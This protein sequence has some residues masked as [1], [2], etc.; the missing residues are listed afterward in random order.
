M[1]GRFE[2]FGSAGPPSGWRPAQPQSHEA[3]WE[4]PSFS[5]QR[6]APRTARERAPVPL[7]DLKIGEGGW[8]DGQALRT[9]AD[10]QIWVNPQSI[11]QNAYHPMDA[12]IYLQ[13]DEYA[14]LADLRRHSSR[15]RGWLGKPQPGPI[16]GWDVPGLYGDSD[17]C[18]SSAGG[19]PC[20]A[21]CE[22]VLRVFF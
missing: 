19:K 18:H 17:A 9:D 5:M 16:T 6:P 2:F 22:P 3:P 14:W 21:W 7:K 15:R 13:R 10:G 20:G 1:F 11:A 8:V 12:P 4:A